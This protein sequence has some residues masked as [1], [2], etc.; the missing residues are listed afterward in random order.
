MVTH[1]RVSLRSEVMAG[2]ARKALRM[3]SRF[4]FPRTLHM[5]RVMG[6]ELSL[7]TLSLLVGLITLSNIENNKG[8][9]LSFMPIEHFLFQNLNRY[10]SFTIS[11]IKNC[12]N[13]A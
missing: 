1:C 10:T 2:E 11:I 5:R 13:T 3:T 12:E 9:E 6:I 7:N 4:L 8:S